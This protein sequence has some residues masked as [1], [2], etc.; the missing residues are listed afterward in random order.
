VQAF[1]A[2][3]IT[4]EGEGPL[5]C[6]PARCVT[7]SALAGRKRRA[8][9]Y[10]TFSRQ[11]IVVHDFVVK[12]DSFGACMHAPCAGRRQPARSP[13]PLRADLLADFPTSRARGEGSKWAPVHR[14]LAGQWWVEAPVNERA[15]PPATRK[16]ALR[17]VRALGATH[18][19]SMRVYRDWLLSQQKSQGGAE[20]AVQAQGATRPEDVRPRAASGSAVRAA[21]LSL[22][23]PG[24]ATSPSA[25]RDSSATA[26]EGSDMP[27][28]PPPMPVRPPPTSRTGTPVD[29]GGSVRPTPAAASSSKDDQILHPR[30][31]RETEATLQLLSRRGV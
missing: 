14:F 8:L 5:T 22:E 18:L 15:Q 7:V 20:A 30:A 6:C 9:V 4:L 13:A 11:L 1:R 17:L 26:S 12:A 28:R 31:P 16:D 29:A 27:A 10:A 19:P 23:V 24:S 25:R 2:G 21:P 3:H